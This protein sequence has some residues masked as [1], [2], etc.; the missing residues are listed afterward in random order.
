MSYEPIAIVGRAVV[1]P[2]ALSPAA[3][4][5]LVAEGR[6]AVTAV[7]TGRF[8]LDP[9]LVRGAPGAG[10]DKTWS[11]RGGYVDVD[12]ASAAL[13]DFPG[14]SDVA[15]LDP[16]FRW[17]L[18]TSHR[19]LCDAGFDGGLK[20]SSSHRGG[21]VFGNLSFPT[22]AMVR[23][24]EA[25]ALPP[26]WRAAVDR[27]VGDR[28]DRQMSG[29]PA[30]LAARHLGLSSFAYCLDAACASSLYAIHLA[31]R[32]LQAGRADVV[33][34]G[35]V[36]RADSLF[37]HVGFTALQALSVL[38]E[39]R[40]F[41]KAADGLVPAEGACALTLMRLADAQREGR[42]IH[43]VITGSALS[44]DGRAKS[45]LA[46]S[47]AGQVRAVRGAWEAA[48]KNPATAGFFECHATGT[49]TGD[50]T[51][52]ETLAT[53]LGN[54]VDHPCMPLSSLKSNLGHLIT[55]AGAAGLVKVLEAM[56]HE[57]LPPSIGVRNPI[58]L[59]DGR[60]FSVQQA[61]AA[62]PR[63]AGDV[64]RVGVSAFGFGGNDAHVV[65]EEPGTL[66]TF[67]A[68]AAIETA[69][70]T[71][72]VVACAVRAGDERGGAEL[73]LTGQ[74]GAATT[75]VVDTTGLRVQPNDLKGAIAQQLLVFEA[76]RDAVAAIGD[77]AAS[78]LPSERTGVFVGMGADL[79]VTTPG[80][81]FR[82]EH[83]ARA[84]GVSDP[85][86]V[87]RLRDLAMPPMGATAVL[88]MMP[89]IPAN[90]L[91]V[92]LDLRG[93]GFTV[94]SEARS[95]L[96][97][98][99]VARSLI[100][101]G[102]LDAAIVGAV[103]AGADPRHLQGL[104]L[105]GAGAGADAAV[106]LVVMTPTRAASLGLTVL[107]LLDEHHDLTSPAVVQVASA[108]YVAQ[109][110]AA[111]AGL[112]AVAQGIAQAGR[113]AVDVV[114]V[115]DADEAGVVGPGR[116]RVS[117][118]PTARRDDVA[119]I[120]GPVTSAIAPTAP[121]FL[122][123]PTVAARLR[124][125]FG[126]DVAAMGAGTSGTPGC[127]RDLFMGALHMLAR[128]SFVRD[129]AGIA[130]GHHIGVSLGESASLVAAG[131]WRDPLPL[132]NDTIASRLFVD[133]VAGERR[134]VS[135]WWASVGK[136]ALGNAWSTAVV[137][138]PR[139]QLQAVVNGTADVT[140]T[141]WHTD[142]EAEIAGAPDAVLAVARALNTTP[143]LLPDAP[144]VHGP[145]IAAAADRYR[146]LHLRDCAAGDDVVLWSNGVG[147]H[148]GRLH[149]RSADACAAAIVRQASR[150][151]DVPAL[152][153]SAWDAGV[154]TFIDVSPRGLVGS[155]CRRILPDARVIVIDDDATASAR[156]LAAAGLTTGRRFMPSKTIDPQRQLQVPAHPTPAPWPEPHI[157]ADNSVFV[158]PQPPVRPRISQADTVGP[159][160]IGVSAGRAPSAA[161][162]QG[163]TVPRGAISA[164]P[165]LPQ[166]SKTP[167]KTVPA[168][169]VSPVP[170]VAAVLSPVHT[171][172]TET[173]PRG[174]ISA[175]Q[176]RAPQ[177][178][179]TVPSGMVSLPI[180]RDDA[181]LAAVR[182][183]R[184]ALA[185]AHAGFVNT[186]SA[187]HS[188]FL[189]TR[190][191]LLQGVLQLDG[192]AAQPVAQHD[193]PTP[194]PAPTSPTALAPV[195]H[196]AALAAA[197]PKAPAAA[198]AAVAAPVA[199]PVAASSP[200]PAVLFDRRQ[201][202]SLATDKISRVLGPLFARQD[203]FPRQVRMPEP[204]LLL[205]DR[206]LSTTATP[207][208]LQKGQS[209]YTAAD[210]RPDAWYL[211]DGRIPA[212]ILIE[213][214]QAD[215]LLISMMGVDFE[216]RGERCYRLLGCDLSYTDHLPLV[217]TVLHHSIFIDG[218]ATAAISAASEARI[219]FF[220]SDT[221][222]GDENGPVVLQVRN[223]Q[224][225]FFTDEELLH[226]GGV[227]WKPTDDNAAAIAAMPHVPP[228]QPSQKTSLTR[229]E[230]LAWS[231]GQAF[232]C[233]GA[234]FE[235]C[236]THVRTPRIEAPRD[237]VDAFGNP[238]GRA[239]DLLL[240]DRV[241]HVD[242]QGGPWG[243]GY[244]R[245]ELDL[246]Q[247]KWFYDGHFKDDPC[248]PG[249]VMF[250]GCLQAASTILAAR[251]DIID[252]DGFRFEPKLA[253]QMRLRCRGQATPTSKHLVYEVFVKSVG[254]GREPELVC[255]IL[256]T[257]DGLKSLHC[258][259]LV[260][261]LVADYPLSERPDL[262]GV[263]SKAD[264]R[265]AIAPRTVAGSSTTAPVTGF[266]SL[267]STGIG[268]PG[269]AFPGL[270]D[271]YDDGSPVARMPGP[272]YHF[273][274]N[275]DAISGPAMGSVFRGENPAGT[276]ASVR[277]DV[278]ADAWYFDEAQA[279]QGGH[280]PFAVLLEVALQPCGWLSSYV[281]S[282]RTSESP[283]KYRN[284]DG[285]A[286]QHREIP[287]DI[288]ALVTHAEI[289][290][291]SSSGGMIIQ[292]FRFDVR[293]QDG[294]RVFD[295]TTVFGFFPQ[296]A[297]ERQVGT[298]SSDEEK[299]RLQ[300][301]S[302]LPGFPRSFADA[303]TWA[304]LA[305]S[306]LHL[307]ALVGA[308]PLLMIDRVEG[309]WRTPEGRL[310]VRTSKDVVLDDWFFKAHFFRDPVQP[311]SLG[312]EAMVQALQFAAGYDNVAAHLQRPRFEALACGR[313]LTWKYRGQVV[314]KNTLIQVEATVTD[315]V[316]ASDG[317]VTVI[318]DGALWVD[319]LRIYLAKGL[320][321]RI[322]EG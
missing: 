282:T 44:N 272:P 309:A 101:A 261:Q 314:P 271:V 7:P 224:A 183:Q 112:A 293:D 276:R 94:S 29:L 255:D 295:G 159:A 32:A 208:V 313:P 160:A 303:A 75:I 176:P 234:G 168:G 254:G 173:V 27:P 243:R 198:T 211:H 203:S 219:F 117:P 60:R 275:V 77:D 263:V 322:V 185:A 51:E 11:T 315:I 47:S 110:L 247:D 5:S 239:I 78:A 56:A 256:V 265:D 132:L 217:G 86:F 298:G 48:N 14:R 114:D 250:Q 210:V 218:F 66:R 95:G 139:A 235:M 200:S 42:P 174:A 302:G 19:A 164:P 36:N 138:A 73:L 175:P 197:P 154:R 244:L 318:G 34:A 220:H 158:L 152:L 187:A 288:G 103:E 204:P 113:V 115:V 87:A 268:R 190:G 186:A 72:A 240:L 206:V 18:G 297:L 43:G 147:D 57:S 195:P 3:L 127:E 258:A 245:A 269:A 40:P 49:Q 180:G 8:G 149:D 105:A 292:E 63:P 61:C 264:G 231:T 39:P 128:A 294:G 246:H 163:Q 310:R 64:R 54:D 212:G 222:L 201:L 23:L 22:E 74:V 70:L 125:W 166:P 213:T 25:L 20:G 30:V 100:G 16:L 233:F 179:E 238:D 216:N 41:D 76:A 116:L 122:A 21:L 205:C 153:R 118:V 52:V 242:L 141:M 91:N 109:G 248:M 106:A 144:A 241:T 93:P 189:A 12:A 215:L 283:L 316:T 6:S 150:T 130:C 97:A 321:I 31:A 79:Q 188:A 279:S 126:D 226:S 317:S 273:M 80:L 89:N 120:F 291:S 308:P 278:P 53:V 286:T 262:R 71:L 35:A 280:M 193:G 299:A 37:L 13:G 306:K 65:V 230:L 98:L 237:G 320:A 312:I 296:L 4:W 228:V 46:P 156:A 162:G 143:A 84:R 107:A 151:V 96:D 223:G 15:D 17:V 184:A 307:P 290:K 257:V 300:A 2:G 311:G 26:S 92:Q 281:G 227:L 24:G 260:L 99:A 124:R 225:G 123:Q 50:R 171:V 221:R 207:G 229:D 277:Y 214:G 45:L 285:T 38:G 287:R 177:S 289:T 131:V 28:R 67:H 82:A 252:S 104:R 62:W 301:E 305:P 133:D 55:A 182:A 10:V 178:P 202:E 274:S 284:L 253:A 90:R 83:F 111:A 137:R 194:A 88:G 196:L 270:Y 146:S 172:A 108:P 165:A 121:A 209:M 266:Q 167:P 119:L 199:A 232:A 170:A 135:A 136:P 161:P 148:G 140:V 102:E 142:D 9:D 192:T 33:V 155:W 85:A 181:V 251:G 169:M 81:R 129:V 259:D 69:P 319:G 304:Q 59:V 236:Q 191:R 134:A 157:T 249:T 58:D 145:V 1:L 267:I 68:S